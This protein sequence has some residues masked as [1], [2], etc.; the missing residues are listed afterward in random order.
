MDYG[1]AS[2]A[3]F[4]MKTI[5]VQNVSRLKSIFKIAEINCAAVIIET[6][7]FHRCVAECAIIFVS[8]HATL[9]SYRLPYTSSP[10]NSPRMSITCTT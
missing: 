3:K 6:V 5:T 8:S 1:H 4:I 2:R 9:S 10:T 7:A